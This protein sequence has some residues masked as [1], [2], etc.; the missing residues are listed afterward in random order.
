MYSCLHD[1]QDDKPRKKAIFNA[2]S[3]KLYQILRKQ[4]EFS[5]K[6]V[7]LVDHI[8]YGYHVKYIPAKFT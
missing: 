4:I 6:K 2:A 1:K 5:M 3:F 8:D 7:S